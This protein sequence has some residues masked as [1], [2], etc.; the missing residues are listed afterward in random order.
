MEKDDIKITRDYERAVRNISKGWN[1]KDYLQADRFS[2]LQKVADY[3]AM[4][5]KM[6]APTVKHGE[7]ITPG[8]RG[9]H[10]EGKNESYLAPRGMENNYQAIETMTH[11]NRHCAQ[12]QAKTNEDVRQRFTEEQMKSFE[13]PYVQ[14]NE[15]F[16]AYYN[17]PKEVDARQAAE[18]FREQFENDVKAIE[19]ADKD[20]H[21]RG[22]QILETYDYNAMEYAENHSVSYSPNNY[23]SH[24][25][26]EFESASTNQILQTPELDSE[27]I[28]HEGCHEAEIGSEEG[29][30]LGEESDGIGTGIDES[31]M[32][33]DSGIDI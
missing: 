25:S 15:N 26:N 27:N 19:Y 1:N 20:L 4:K 13:E 24:E 16:E 12:D 32:S 14:P 21:F 28:S 31:E 3:Q 33:E 30:N 18:K 10:Y 7:Q 29:A 2:D 22:N 8:V 11:E 5:E 9:Y 23:L 6:D 17:H